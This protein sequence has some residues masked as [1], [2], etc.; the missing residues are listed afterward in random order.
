MLI[1]SSTLAVSLLVL[2]IPFWGMATVEETNKEDSQLVQ[3][4]LDGIL[5]LTEEL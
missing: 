3:E 1:S 4:I 2:A 5:M